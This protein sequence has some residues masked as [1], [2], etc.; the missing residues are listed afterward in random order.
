MEQVSFLCLALCT[1]LEPV[2]FE[3]FNAF[4][5]TYVKKTSKSDQ[6]KLKRK[7]KHPGEDTPQSRRKGV[8]GR[9]KKNPLLESKAVI[10]S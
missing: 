8:F 2:F 1:L 3:K 5:L 7:K 10:L 4:Y 6:L 9:S